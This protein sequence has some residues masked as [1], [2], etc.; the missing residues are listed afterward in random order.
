MDTNRIFH[1]LAGLSATILLFRSLRSRTWGFVAA[2]LPA[3]LTAV[4]GA[5]FFPETA[6]TITLALWG[7]LVLLPLFG[8]RL[9][10]RL[11]SR[12]RYGAAARFS[13][14]LR[15][16]HPADGWWERHRLFEALDLGQQGRAEEAAAVLEALSTS[17][18][19]FARE[20]R[21]HLLR[22]HGRWEEVIA[23]LDAQQRGP[24]A[25]RDP[26]L[27]PIYLRA[28]GETGEI[29]RLVSLYAASEA[30]LGRAGLLA[31]RNLCRLFVFAFTGRAE[32]V[33]ALFKGPLSAYPD[34]LQT[35]WRATAELALDP[36]GP[37]RAA[38]SGMLD[39]PD[40]SLRI[41]V[42]RRLDQPLVD[43]RQ[44]LRPEAMALLDRIEREW[45]QEERY[46]PLTGGFRPYATFGLMAPILAMF[47]AEELR[48][49]SQDP[50]ALLKLGAFWP[51]LVLAGEWWRLGAA[52]LLHYGAL[53]LLM[54]LGGLYVLGPYVEFAL[55]RVRYVIVYVFAGVGTMLAVALL[56]S[57]GLLGP[58]LLVG[59]SGAIMGL[60]GATGAVMWRGQRREGSAIARRRLG[61]VVMI[62]G[63]QATFDAMVPQVSSLSHFGGAVLGFLIA[64]AMSHRVTPARRPQAG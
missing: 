59:A 43:P 36:D 35:F 23:W 45:D 3:V 14:V 7:L 15:F 61:G 16:L 20:A 34:T 44:A 26:S 27:L 21:V 41:S 54:N 33:T 25:W 10:G 31:L 2:S 42:R 53:H 56:S 29:E 22:M 9:L 64:S 1:L 46:G 11:V 8:Q 6:G 55:G 58:Q 4:A 19:T 18:Q 52:T 57:A 49:G 12:Q 47:A 40:A 37:A 60:V 13:R 51:D 62:V 32:R 28:L 50:E 30:L 24:E 48:G 63:V 17:S 39:R 5:F 38:L